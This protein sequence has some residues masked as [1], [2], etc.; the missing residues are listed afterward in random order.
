MVGFC[1]G[2]G[3][4]DPTINVW[5]FRAAKECAWNFIDPNKAVEL[6]RSALTRPE[7]QPYEVT[8]AVERAYK[9]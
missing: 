3:P 2:T 7:K 8:R 6:I 1:P 9:G 4:N 5:I